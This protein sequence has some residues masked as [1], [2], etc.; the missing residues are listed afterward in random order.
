MNYREGQERSWV[1]KGL[2]GDIGGCKGLQEGQK[3]NEP[4]ETLL[5]GR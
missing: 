5:V 2:R 1:T 4:M 3:T